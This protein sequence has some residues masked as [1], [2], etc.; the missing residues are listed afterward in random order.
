MQD[1]LPV[2]E[3]RDVLFLRQVWKN[4]PKIRS[5]Q[6]RVHGNKALGVLAGLSP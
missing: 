1:S 5:G 3:I 6:N 4:A 2:E